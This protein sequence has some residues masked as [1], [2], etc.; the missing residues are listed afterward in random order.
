VCELY[1]AS[2]VPGGNAH[3]VV[4]GRNEQP[5]LVFYSAAAFEAGAAWNALPLPSGATPSAYAATASGLLLLDT[6]G[7]AWN[8][9]GVSGWTALP[10]APVT[11]PSTVAAVGASGDV[12]VLGHGPAPSSKAVALYSGVANQWSVISGGESCALLAAFETYLVCAATSTGQLLQANLTSPAPAFVPMSLAQR[13]PAGT[14]Q[15]VAG[16]GGALWLLAD[17]QPHLAPYPYTTFVPYPLPNA[18]VC[19]S[20]AADAVG[21]ASAGNFSLVPRPASLQVGDDTITLAADCQLVPMGQSGSSPL[22]K[23]ALARYSALL[24][25]GGDGSHTAGK[26]SSVILTT[27]QTC[28]VVNVAVAQPQEEQRLGTDESYVLVLAS[29]DNCSI[30]AVTV[31]GAMRGLETLAQLLELGSVRTI[32]AV[33]IRD[34][35]R[36]IYR[37]AAKGKV[38]SMAVSSLLCAFE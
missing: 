27:Q 21:L 10:D 1:N 18:A 16:L 23:A 29:S 24:C 22:L 11:I 13:A 14:T 26:R 35:P 31:V 30:S 12:V 38:E 25:Q 34:Q 5:G 20:L 8:T 17:G 36:F 28:K 6:T 7:R 33:L 37:Q 15:L 32:P 3:G 4:W 19:H 2:I 9:R